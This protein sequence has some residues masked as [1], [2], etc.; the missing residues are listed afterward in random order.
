M[1]QTLYV[2]DY[3]FIEDINPL[4][5][6]KI[7]I[8]GAGDYGKRTARLLDEF[9]VRFE[10]FCDKDETKKQY[11][12][13]PVITID[14]LKQKTDSEK[15]LVIVGSKIYCGEIVKELYAK[16]IRAYV[17]TWYG[18]KAGIDIN[19]NDSRLPEA[20][21]KSFIYRKETWMRCIN[22]GDCDS[23]AS[24]LQNQKVLCINPSAILVYQCGKVGS[25]TIWRSI[26]RNNMDAIHI[27]FMRHT[28]V[29]GN[30]MLPKYKGN[31][32]VGWTE[33]I[34]ELRKRKEPLKMIVSVR[35][36]VGRALSAFM[37]YFSEDFVCCY[38]TRYGGIKENAYRFMEKYLKEDYE[39]TWW[40]DEELK[41]VTGIDVY[42][43]PFDRERG[44]ARISE[45]GIEILL[46]K[47]DKISEN[48]ALISEFVGTEVNLI[49][50]NVGATKRYSY[51]YERLKKEIRIPAE[52]VKESYSNERYRHFYTEDETK[53]FLKKWIRE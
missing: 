50:S 44:F 11:L 43:Y 14:E 37:E 17:C 19:I 10:C 23:H 49:A 28:T 48:Q 25:A 7:I 27:H 5:E 40:F 1:E 18:V 9:C 15:Y 34:A 13:H 22:S 52:L 35:E 45:D 32:D 2:K 42:Q 51:I 26:M 31:G 20:E 21:V 30:G 39:F 53:R 6:R 36:P 38:D 3:E 8:Y 33:T 16:E 12:E 24:R 46:L 29:W 41:A 47:T 4:F